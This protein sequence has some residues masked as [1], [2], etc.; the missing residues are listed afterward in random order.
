MWQLVA[1]QRWVS[2]LAAAQPRVRA[3]R[4]LCGAEPQDVARSRPRVGAPMWWLPVGTAVL[5][6]RAARFWVGAQ[7]RSY[8][9][10]LHLVRPP[11]TVQGRC[12]SGQRH[13]PRSSTPWPAPIPSATPASS[14]TRTPTTPR[15]S[16]S[17]PPATT[18]TTPATTTTT[19]T[20]AFGPRLKSGP[21]KVR[22]AAGTR[23]AAG[24]NAGAFGKG[25]QLPLYSQ[26]LV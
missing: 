16:P 2:R 1:T 12:P 23:G 10:A 21:H 7:G 5:I 17:A 25:L 13:R 14:P 4:Q 22:H 19:R 26:Y 18:A 8:S 15:A 24:Q 9:G 20:D 6:P 11:R 3:A